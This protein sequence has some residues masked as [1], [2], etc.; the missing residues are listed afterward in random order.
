[1]H[2]IASD[3]GVYLS[4]HLLGRMT[5]ENHLGPGITDYLLNLLVPRGGRI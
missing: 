2:L 1:M 5:Q 4:S 3:S